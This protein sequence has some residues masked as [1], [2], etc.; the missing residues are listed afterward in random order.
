MLGCEKGFLATV[1]FPMQAS[2]LNI[3]IAVGGIVLG[4][5]VGVA[6]YITL[7]THQG[8]ARVVDTVIDPLAHLLPGDAIG[9]NL[10]AVATSVE[11]EYACHHG[12][13]CILGGMT[14]HAAA[15]KIVL[16]GQQ[17][18]GTLHV[19]C[20]QSI[21]TVDACSRHI[22]IVRRGANGHRTEHL[23]ELIVGKRPQKIGL[24]IMAVFTCLA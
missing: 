7:I 11:Q 15:V 24:A 10:L 12:F 1:A 8:I 14:S 19:A 2:I 13:G 4:C 22:V 5:L 3:G 9:Q 17:I 16:I 18:D 20:Y 21:N 23:S 6:P